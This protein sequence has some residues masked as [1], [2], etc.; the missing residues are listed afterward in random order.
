VG[1]YEKRDVV[2]IGGGILGT[3]AGVL[4]GEW[5]AFPR[6]LLE[7]RRTWPGGASGVTSGRF[8]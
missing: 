4:S 2:V 7:R 6:F 1:R 8:R 3:A 5:R